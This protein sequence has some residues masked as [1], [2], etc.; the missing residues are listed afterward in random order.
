MRENEQV[1]FS[2][3]HEE[4]TCEWTWIH[5][6]N[7]GESTAKFYCMYFHWICPALFSVFEVDSELI[8]SSRL[9]HCGL[10][11]VIKKSS[12][13]QEVS[14]SLIS[15]RLKPSLPL[16]VP[17]FCAFPSHFS[18]S[19]FLLCDFK[20][21]FKHVWSRCTNV[22]TVITAQQG[23]DWPWTTENIQRFFQWT[24][25]RSVRVTPPTSAAFTC[26]SG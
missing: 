6:L 8:T 22:R 9:E 2:S 14:P 10:H 12:V 3:T 4:G 7:Q 13:L 17:V 23:G 1:L 11:D 24:A 19:I 15:P 20:F 5:K 21:D 18:F 25:A 16:T 26:Q